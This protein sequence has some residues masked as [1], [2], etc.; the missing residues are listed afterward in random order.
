M[1]DD[2]PGSPGFW[3][4]PGD[5]GAGLPGA[6]AWGPGAR[7][8]LP[9]L[10]A[11]AHSDD[12]HHA[13]VRDPDGLRSFGDRN[14]CGV[15]YQHTYLAMPGAIRPGY[16]LVQAVQPGPGQVADAGPFRGDRV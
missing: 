16:I 14:Y 1:S 6:S 7:S 15:A 12:A 3:P 8:G 2:G 13:P 10:H 5:S 11:E 4:P 9:E